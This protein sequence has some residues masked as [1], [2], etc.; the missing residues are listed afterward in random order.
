MDYTKL[1]PE[2]FGIDNGSFKT[3]LQN[4]ELPELANY[5]LALVDLIQGFAILQNEYVEVDKQ[6]DGWV[7]QSPT[8]IFYGL[9]ILKSFMIS[10]E[11]LSEL[12]E[13]RAKRVKKRK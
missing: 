5:Q 9:E 4:A 10:K 6:F 11:Q 1:F 13:S 8:P 7:T 12:E 3:T 2:G